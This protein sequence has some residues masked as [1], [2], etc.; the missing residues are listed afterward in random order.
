M[1]TKMVTKMPIYCKLHRKQYI[2]ETHVPRRQNADWSFLR[3]GGAF[4]RRAF[5][6]R[7]AEAG[8]NRSELALPPSALTR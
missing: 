4:V 8:H 5:A 1:S 2:L 3:T 7:A 6:D